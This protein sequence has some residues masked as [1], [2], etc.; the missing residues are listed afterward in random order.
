VQETI[1]EVHA[2]DIRDILEL[3]HVLRI[4]GIAAVLCVVTALVVGF[5]QAAAATAITRLCFPLTD[6]RWPRETELQLV[7]TELVPLQLARGDRLR[8]AFGETREL[9]VENRRGELP[10]DVRLIVRSEKG[11][12][13][14]KTVTLERRSIR[15][16]QGLTRQFAIVHLEGSEK[17]AFRVVGG[18]DTTMPWHTLRVV[19]PPVVTSLRLTLTPPAYLG[20]PPEVLPEGVGH[21]E[22]MIGTRVEMQGR[23]NKPVREAALRIRDLEPIAIDVDKEHSQFQVAF[24]VAEAGTYSYWFQLLDRQGFENA[25]APRY[26]I[27]ALADRVPTVYID[28][29]TGDA[30]VTPQA[31]L[32]VR[33][34]ARDDLALTGLSLVYRVNESSD[35]SSVPLSLPAS[36]EPLSEAAAEI[37]WDLAQ[38]KLTAGMRVRLHA[39]A[40]D[41]F[42][43]AGESHTGKS[44]VRILTIVTPEEKLAELESRQTELLEEIEKAWRTQKRAHAQAR[45]VLLQ[46]STVGR[47]RAQDVDTLKRVELDQRQVTARLTNPVDGLE[48]RVGELLESIDVNRLEAPE[49]TARL[50]HINTELADLRE[51]LLPRIQTRLTTSLKSLQ[52]GTESGTDGDLPTSL[53]RVSEDQETIVAV[54]GGL[55]DSL[56]QWKRQRDFEEDLAAL[57]KSQSDV[58]R[59]TVEL[60][61]TTLGRTFDALGPQDQA[62]LIKLGERQRAVAD[63]LERFRGRLDR[64]LEPGAENNGADADSLRDVRDELDRRATT[65]YVRDA[66]RAI[67]TNKMGD[68]TERQTRIAADLEELEGILKNRTV[69]DLDSLVKKLGEQELQLQ[70]LSQRQRDVVEEL[71]LHKERPESESRRQAL[72]RLSKEQRKIRKESL[73]TLRRLRRLRAPQAASSSGRAADRMAESAQALNRD[74][75]DDAEAPAREAL[76]DLTQARRELARAR[77]ELAEQLASEVRERLGDELAGLVKRQESLIKETQR[78]ENRRA[79][80]TSW[81]R[82]LLQTLRGIAKAQNEL[83][84]DTLALKQPLDSDDVTGLALENAAAAMTAARDEL[85]RRRTGAE[86]LRQQTRARDGLR[87]LLEALK[88]DTPQKAQGEQP[89]E[90][91]DGGTGSPASSL[92]AQL[93][94]VK[95]LQLDINQET[96]ELEALRDA[97]AGLTPEQQ[98]RFES[99]AERQTVLAERTARLLEALVP[100]GDSANNGDT[101]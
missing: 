36:E 21:F 7:D 87:G 62:E 71:M 91:Q 57:R 51:Q 2:Y 92:T 28:R 55:L 58:N 77:R 25:D 53:Q 27:R 38:L 54:L 80:R 20:K 95:L 19:A 35:E 49:L 30:L 52:A 48:H 63:E 12:R 4:A 43:L 90:T 94:I 64:A 98:R 68:A 11:K 18:D 76:D 6:H 46:S 13:E 22:A 85:D 73:K 42:N 70:K 60:G 96:A 33:A 32:R 56:D 67:R 16:E 100:A 69:D 65:G 88:P 15:D 82:S 83:E 10:D 39:I 37:D 99:L 44:A 84:E 97:P 26:E 101:P 61:R 31:R 81:S 45:E 1:R 86:A 75:A 40:S 78:L 34:S 5:N 14:L 74:R 41:A 8:I 89:P 24:D 72:A 50:R 23:L 66:A 59:Q 29:P 79:A 17:L 3:R 47:L 9:L 93:K